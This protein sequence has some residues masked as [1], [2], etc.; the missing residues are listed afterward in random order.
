MIMRRQ[1]WAQS[2]AAVVAFGL[3]CAWANAATTI[4]RPTGSFPLDTHNVQAAVDQGGTVLLKATDVTGHPMAFNFGPPDPVTGGGVALTTDV[5]ILGERV[6]PRMTTIAGGYHPFVGQTPAKTHI[7]GLDF[8]A[9]LAAPIILLASTG[10]EI[11]GNHINGVIGIR[12]RFGTDGDGIDLFGNDDPHNAITGHVRITDNVIENLG[13]DFANGM[14]LDEVAADVEITGNTVRFPQSNGL[15]QTYG[16]TAFRCHNRVSIVGNSVTM[17][18][19]NPDA[20]PA[21]IFIAGDLDA[22]YFIALNNLVSNHPNGDG[23]IVNGGDLSEPTEGAVIE[24]NRITINSQYAEQFD[25]SYFGLAGLDVFG[26]VNNSLITGNVIRGTSAFAISVGGFGD[27]ANADRLIWNDFSQHT[28]LTTDVYFDSFTSNMV[29]D[30]R[31]TSDIDQGVGNQINCAARIGHAP[32]AALKRGADVHGH[33]RDVSR[34]NIR[35][36]M[37]NALRQWLPK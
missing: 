34:M 10:A 2:I 5:T 32:A 11:V 15:I 8:E 9:P 19:G 6:G 17:G 37:L 25:G 21:P 28:S 13:A 27:S 30:G 36:D 22:H 23:I 26:A 16:I 24:L 7:E 20:F 18:P 29:L 31:C 14:Q 33:L 3:H 12:L 35:G 1:L 4:V